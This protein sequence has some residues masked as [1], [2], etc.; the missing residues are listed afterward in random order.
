MNLT[1][2]TSGARGRGPWQIAEEEWKPEP[3]HALGQTGMALV[4][5]LAVVAVIVLPGVWFAWAGEVERRARLAAEEERRGAYV[6]LISS[7]ALEVL[8]VERTAHGRDLFV[9]ACVLCHGADG[10]GVAGLGKDLTRSWFV[11]SLDDASLH[12]FLREGRAA[13]HPDNTTRMPMPPRGGRDDLSDDDLAD[14]ALY[15]RGLQDPR[16]MPELPAV[17]AVAPKPPSEDEMAAALAAAGGDEELAEWIASGSKLFAAS[18]AAC[19]GKDARGIAGNGK[20]LVNSEFCDSLDDDSLLEFIKKGRDPGDPANTT[21]VGM[22]AK[23]GNPALSDDDILDII[24]YLRSLKTT[25][26]ATKD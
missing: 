2:P 8:P 26:A 24:A 21:G 15:L 3:G 19:H 10:T 22:P 4:A 9:S 7:P 11:A 14:I 25:A 6:R 16:R 1:S 23:G 18:C 13:D 17:A 20:S 12:D 5:A